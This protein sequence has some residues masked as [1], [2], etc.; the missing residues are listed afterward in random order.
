MEMLFM[1][2]SLIAAF[3]STTAL[4]RLDFGNNRTQRIA[5]CTD[6]L[7]YKHSDI[8]C[9]LCPAGTHVKLHCTKPHNKGVCEECDYGATFIEHMNGFT[10]CWKC[11]TCRS[12]QEIVRKCSSTQDTE[13]QCRL[14][15]FCSP[16]QPC[17]VC[18][19]CLRCEKDEEIVRNC[20]ATT[21]TK[22]KKIQ[23]K[24]DISSDSSAMII[25]A[26][27]L[28][29]GFIVVVVCALCWWKRRHSKPGT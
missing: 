28:S 25:A 10:E 4:P 23:Q 9:L 17:E 6:G 5:H 29:A 7:E 3:A 15:K 13:C 19:K 27:L 8:C 14:G 24:S 1:T 2:I 21:N 11:T 22:C 16:D 26:L 18:K 12:D 20:T